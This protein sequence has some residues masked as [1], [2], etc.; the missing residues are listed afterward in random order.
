MKRG[1]AMRRIHMRI[2]ELMEE[3]N[4]S[5]NRICEDLHLQRG[6]F[7]KYCRDEYYQIDTQLLL[8]LCDYLECDIK[9]L[10]VIVDD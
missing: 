7:N 4:I 9:D 8:K 1:R 6:N 2:L 10:V 3:K 5:K